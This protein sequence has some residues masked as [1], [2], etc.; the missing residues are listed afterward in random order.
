M[1]EFG[2]A[3]EMGSGKVRWRTIQENLKGALVSGT[4]S[5]ITAIAVSADSEWLAYGRRNVGVAVLK[6]HGGSGAELVF[7][8][9]NSGLSGVITSIY[10][11]RTGAGKSASYVLYAG[12]QQGVLAS[13]HFKDEHSTIANAQVIATELGGITS[14]H[15]YQEEL[16]VAVKDGT[17]V[18]KLSISN[19]RVLQDFPQCS[20]PPIRSITAAKHIKALIVSTQHRHLTAYSLADPKSPQYLSGESAPLHVDVS[21]HLFEQ[22]YQHIL[23]V[24]ELGEIAV[25]KVS[26]STTSK[27]PLQPSTRIKLDTAS[28]KGHSIISAAFSHSHPGS[29]IISYGTL[30]K[31]HFI[32]L[33]Y[34][35]ESTGLL[36][37]KLAINSSERNTLLDASTPNGKETKSSKERDN[38]D[39]RGRLAGAMD[40]TIAHP[41]FKGA[42]AMQ[43][44]SYPQDAADIPFS[45]L[46][47]QQSESG[48]GTA[49]SHNAKESSKGKK[50]LDLPR[51]TSAVAALVSALSTNDRTQLNLIL[52]QHDEQFIKSTLNQL[53]VSQ[54]LPLLSELLTNFTTKASLPIISW[55][56]HLLILHQSY[57]ASAPD[58]INKLSGLYN[59]VD[60]RLKNFPDLLKLSGRFDLLL[61]HLRYQ[62]SSEVLGKR[63]L[64]TYVEEEDDLDMPDYQDSDESDAS[65]SD[66]ESDGET[67]SDMSDD[68]EDSE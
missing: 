7:P 2:L 33:P 3:N 5:N 24:S 26:A 47:K 54:V 4:G 53:P 14:I 28:A 56:R 50:T 10:L 44:D 18:V 37:A 17:K 15:E 19:G 9:T 36:Q 68:D 41:T 30:A 67:G 29:I 63:A 38:V 39:A 61:A 25:W 65:G 51:A 11:H 34:V 35:D 48:K 12:D 66:E 58:L 64:Q 27:K 21:P 57:L 13:W 16:Y 45:Q 8:M 32:D 55:T 62:D 31:P 40:S 22:E 49:A 23:G 60:E 42:D 52:A 1:T 46:V 6:L 43:V 20:S 59:T